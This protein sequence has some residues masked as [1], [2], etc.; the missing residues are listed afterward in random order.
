MTTGI[1]E[2]EERKRVQ[3]LVDVREAVAATLDAFNRLEAPGMRCDDQLITDQLTAVLPP[4]ASQ[5]SLFSELRGLIGSSDA[6]EVVGAKLRNVLR[7]VDN[8][9]AGAKPRD[10]AMLQALQKY[11][12][13]VML[14]LQGSKNSRAELEAALVLQTLLSR[15]EQIPNVPK[16]DF[17][18]LAAQ[19]DVACQAFEDKRATEDWTDA[20]LRE[21]GHLYREV[22]LLL[23]GSIADQE[24][25]F[26]S[27]DTASSFLV[28][29]AALDVTE[30]EAALKQTQEALAELRA[31]DAGEARAFDQ[32]EM[33]LVKY[34]ENCVR[35]QTR[36]AETV[37]K[38]TAHI[39]NLLSD[40]ADAHLALWRESKRVLVVD[41][42]MD[43]LRK[44]QAVNRSLEDYEEEQAFMLEKDLSA[45]IEAAH[46]VNLANEQVSR[47]LGSIVRR[48]RDE[49]AS[50]TAAFVV[51]R[52]RLLSRKHFK[53][54]LATFAIESSLEILKQEREGVIVKKQ[55]SNA[56]QKPDWVRECNRLFA[57]VEARIAEEES[58]LVAT[59][60]EQAGV[61][62]AWEALFDR[63]SAL[64]LG[65]TV[66]AKLTDE[67]D[68]FY[69]SI[70][71][72]RGVEKQ[73]LSFIE[74][75]DKLDA[76]FLAYRA[77]SP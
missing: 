11:G 23:D 21:E 29:P 12:R 20:K 46:V 2:R 60:E 39:S 10:L 13:D 16:P 48:Q 31:A 58:K 61:R 40:L 71:E 42:S 67:R 65:E 44:Q 47:E 35:S 45:G 17:H 69:A 33:G 52:L 50:T 62:D 75:D 68:R 4:V 49:L 76:T 19:T 72:L 5:A 7:S 74:L 63:A 77:T 51:D 57:E 27:Y 9:V 1:A 70:E 25:L 59:Q 32:L 8:A 30:P 14:A 66:R 41:R 53:T 56:A 73:Q 43:L 22:D 6:G 15:I 36:A 26:A 3:E 18:K 54:A 64:D 55:R 37:D 38:L 34:R 28:P 24:A